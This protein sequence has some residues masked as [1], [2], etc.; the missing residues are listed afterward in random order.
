[1]LENGWFVEHWECTNERIARA[2]YSLVG[3]TYKTQANIYLLEITNW[4]KERAL[5]EQSEKET[6][7]FHYCKQHMHACVL[8]VSVMSDSVT[9]WILA[10]Q[11]S[12]SMGFSKLKY[13]SGLPCLPPGYLLDP[14]LNLLLLRLLH[15]QAGSLPLVPPGKP[16]KQHIFNTV[17]EKPY[18]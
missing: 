18:N 2:T 14:G 9:L 11:A 10:H 17:N 12:L 5:S 16:H 3:K 15:W 7:G 13:W 8:S 1:M 6:E 4:L